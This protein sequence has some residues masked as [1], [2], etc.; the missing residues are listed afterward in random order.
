MDRVFLGANALFS[1][2][3]RTDAG[4]LHLWKLRNVTLCSSHYAL[5]EARANLPAED[6]RGRLAALSEVLE[7]FEPGKSPIPRGI[8]LPSKDVPIMLAAIAASATHLLTGD[9]RHF[10][11]YFGK[12]IQGI[13]IV[14]PG[15]YLRMR[16][17]KI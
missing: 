5:E 3:Y 6:Q 16:A 10:G 4:L 9:V 13:E 8:I 2:A 14:L 11:P 1:A 12:R 17:I 15:N 7:L